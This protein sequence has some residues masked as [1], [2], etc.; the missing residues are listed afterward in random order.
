MDSLIW[1]LTGTGCQSKK[2]FTRW[3]DQWQKRKMAT[4]TILLIF[5]IFH[6]IKIATFTDPSNRSFC[7][8]KRIGKTLTLNIISLSPTNYRVFLTA[9]HIITKKVTA[10]WDYHVSSSWLIAFPFL[11]SIIYIALNK[12]NNR[13]H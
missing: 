1:K 7:P 12:L 13:F 8:Y 2:L 3:M 10:N 9:I 5:Q 11:P 4:S 6:K